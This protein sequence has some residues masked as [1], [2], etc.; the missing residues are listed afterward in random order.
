MK[1]HLLLFVVLLIEMANLHQTCEAQSLFTTLD[2]LQKEYPYGACI[3]QGKE[4][5]YLATEE[6]EDRLIFFLDRKYKRCYQLLILPASEESF[7]AT[8]QAINDDWI[9]MDETHWLYKV[10]DRLT[11]LCSVIEPEEAT[12]KAIQMDYQLNTK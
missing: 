12:V 7:E 10:D 11:L 1:R 3:K 8:V 2:E 9:A 5:V 6:S 4:L